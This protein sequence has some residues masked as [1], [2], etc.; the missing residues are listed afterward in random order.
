MIE[1]I[2][3]FSLLLPYCFLI[4]VVGIIWNEVVRAFRGRD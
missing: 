3:G 1:L 2:K 4:C